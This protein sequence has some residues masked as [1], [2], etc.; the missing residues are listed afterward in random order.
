MKRLRLG[1][2][3]GVGV[4]IERTVDVCV[5]RA[6]GSWRD[7]TVCYQIFPSGQWGLCRVAIESVGHKGFLLYAPAGVEVEVPVTSP[8]E[9]VT[10]DA[11]VMQ[12]Q[13]HCEG[14]WMTVRSDVPW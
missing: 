14:D 6:L 4:E 13:F 12:A 11:L 10:I 9:V 8:V 3:P 5:V 1:D 2:R 7:E